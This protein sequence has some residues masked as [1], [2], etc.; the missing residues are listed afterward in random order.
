MRVHHA[1]LAQRKGDVL[2]HGEGREQGA[3][4]E[5]HAIA[6]LAGEACAR[7]ARPQVLAKQGDAAGSRLGEPDEVAQ[8]G[9]LATAGTADQGD[10]LAALDVEVQALMHHLAPEAGADPAQGNDEL[11][12][13]RV[14]DRGL[15]HPG[16]PIE[17]VA[18]AKIASTR[19]TRVME[20]TTEAVVFLDRLSVLGCTRRPKWQAMSAIRKPNTA[21]LASP[22]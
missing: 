9:R 21:P 5:Q 19:M 6:A 12:A 8:Q 15:T 14:R 7:A 20:V 10:D 22:M 18:M 17:R 3:L 13:G 2:G 11:G 16:M 1:Q 4:L